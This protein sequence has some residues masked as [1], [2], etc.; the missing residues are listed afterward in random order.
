MVRSQSYQSW[1]DS[2][3]TKILAKAQGL[4]ELKTKAFQ[5]KLEDW[6]EG[7]NSFSDCFKFGLKFWR[8][9]NTFIWFQETIF[10]IS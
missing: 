5:S 9:K 6:S 10:I 8:N 4:V 2:E 3:L 7:S 1:S